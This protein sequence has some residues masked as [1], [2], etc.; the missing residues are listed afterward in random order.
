[1]AKLRFH[2]NQERIDNQEEVTQYLESQGVPCERWEI[3]KIP[4]RLREKYDLTEEEKA[5]IF[6]VF[7]NE[8]DDLAK[9][10]GYRLDNILSLSSATLDLDQL[11]QRMG[12]EHHH[13][14]YAAH[15][16]VSGHGI[17]TIQVPNGRYVD[18]EKEA[19]DFFCVPEGYRHYFALMADRQMVAI[20]SSI[21]EAIYE[22]DESGVQPRY[23]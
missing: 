21:G 6:A 20:Q 11:L 23:V 2:D 22:K 14:Q 9:R 15:F 17:F 18:V 3:N 1:M 10:R 13:K 12:Q 7:R 4:A 16:M 5:E 19:G 8:I